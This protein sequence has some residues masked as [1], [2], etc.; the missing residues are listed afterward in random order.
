ML[1]I[2]EFFQ[3]NLKKQIINQSFKKAKALLL[4]KK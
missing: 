1:K 4:K 2:K 3:N